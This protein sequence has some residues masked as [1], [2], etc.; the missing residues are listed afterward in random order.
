MRILI[1]NGLV[2]D[3][4]HHLNGT[5]DLLIQDGVIEEVFQT[6]GQRLDDCIGEGQVQGEGQNQGEAQ[7]ALTEKNRLPIDQIIDATG[8]WVVPGFIDL[9]VH[10]RDPGFEY[11]EDIHTGTAA[12]AAGGFTTVCAM[13]N[14]KPVADQAQ[15]VQSVLDKAKTAPVNVLAIGSITKGLMGKE[16][17]DIDDL[18]RAGVCAISDDG[19]SVDDEDL[20]RQAFLKAKEWNLPVFSHCENLKLVNGGVINAGEVS[21]KHGLPGINNQSESDYVARDIRLAMETGARLHI[22]HVSTKESVAVIAQAKAALQAS[23]NVDTQVTIKADSQVSN[24]ADSQA[25][26]TAEATPHHF[27]LC[28]TDIDVNSANFKMSPPLRSKADMEA[29]RAALKDGTI[30][31]IATDHAPHAESEKSSFVSAANG[32]IGLETAFPLSLALVSDGVLSP[33]ELV[34]KLSNQP[35]RI[36]GLDR[37]IAKGKSADLTILDPNKEYTIQAEQFKSKSKNSPFIGKKVKGQVLYT[38][39]KGTIC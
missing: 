11:K 23:A 7:E 34:E 28:D 37:G 21:E 22:C 36:L 10:L 13:P 31:C 33:S 14:T 26:I 17:S 30:D 1:K 5:A 15:V 6:E 2:L 20:L 27:S 3:P 16:L 12:A 19:K 39:A 4:S 32:I 24:Q 35:A 9:H 18:A 8:L 38:L 25:I 29:I